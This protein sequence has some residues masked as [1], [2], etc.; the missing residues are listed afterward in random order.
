MCRWKVAHG[1]RLPSCCG[2]SPSRHQLTLTI[3]KRSLG[4]TNCASAIGAV[5]S[6]AVKASRLLPTEKLTQVRDYQANHGS[7]RRHRCPTDGRGELASAWKNCQFAP[8]GRLLAGRPLRQELG[9][10]RLERFQF[11]VLLAPTPIVLPQL[12]QRLRPRR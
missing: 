9:P 2:P 8:S 7:P 5:Q 6:E 10:G 4:P 3:N 12:R 11:E 1:W